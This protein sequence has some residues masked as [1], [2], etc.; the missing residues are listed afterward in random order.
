[1]GSHSVTY[2]LAVVTFTHV[3]QSKLVLNL[4]TPEGCKAEL[5]WVYHILRELDQVKGHY[6]EFNVPVYV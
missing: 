3:P 1:M 2:H 4:V 6:V 5:T